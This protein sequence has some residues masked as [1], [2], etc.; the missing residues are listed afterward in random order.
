MPTAR[1][2]RMP[3]PPPPPP[4]PGPPPPPTFHQVGRPS[5]RLSRNL[6]A[7]LGLPGVRHTVWEDG[8]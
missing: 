7:Y 5:T 4:P 1:R 8:D 6:N 2:A 3:I